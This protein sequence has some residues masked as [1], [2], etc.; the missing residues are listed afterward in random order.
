MQ[1]HCDTFS[2]ED[3]D[4]LFESAF[5]DCD[6]LTAPLGKSTEAS[7]AAAAAPTYHPSLPP[8]STPIPPALTPC[9]QMAPSPSLS[10]AAGS[11]SATLATQYLLPQ[12]LQQLQI[13]PGAS[14]YA[15]G[16][17][18]GLSGNGF[19]YGP[20]PPWM[21]QPYSFVV[22]RKLLTQG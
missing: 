2:N 8:R 21:H 19:G 3:L 16:P 12:H 10:S 13:Q 18:Y 1:T 5:A 7:R 14:P 6:W 11:S 4:A 22:P 17:Y 9:S 15:F 20:Y